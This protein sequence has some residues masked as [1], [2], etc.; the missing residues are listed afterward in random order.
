M[1]KT[2]HTLYIGI[3]NTKNTVFAIKVYNK[4]LAPECKILFMNSVSFIKHLILLIEIVHNN[5]AAGTLEAN[6]TTGVH[7]INAFAYISLSRF[8][9]TRAIDS[10]L[11]NS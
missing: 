11:F 9:F 1:E 7:H 2:D 8:V 4:H 5:I 10:I 6:L 3:L